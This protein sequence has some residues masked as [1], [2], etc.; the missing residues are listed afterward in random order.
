[1]ITAGIWHNSFEHST[2][3]KFIKQQL[4]RG[5]F[6]KLCV[7]SWIFFFK[8][9]HTNDDIEV[10]LRG[11]VCRDQNLRPRNHLAHDSDIRALFPTR[12]DGPD[13]TPGPTG[14]MR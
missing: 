11:R 14:C 13:D 9:K 8:K 1:M 4:K 3:V 10:D 2:Q 6:K 7:G 12:H 5:I